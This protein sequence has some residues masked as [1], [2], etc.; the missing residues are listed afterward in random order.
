[1]LTESEASCVVHGTP[2]RVAEAGM[3]SDEAVREDM[4]PLIVECLARR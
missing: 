4:A 3:S 1:V 2:R